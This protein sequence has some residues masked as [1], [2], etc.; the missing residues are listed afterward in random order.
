M[1]HF[2]FLFNTFVCRD[3]PSARLIGN[4]VSKCYMP[5]AYP[6]IIHTFYYGK[7]TVVSTGKWSEGRR[8]SKS[9][10]SQS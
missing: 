7:T 6:Y 9:S 5:E 8:F 10:T 4:L 1:T 3:V 2:S